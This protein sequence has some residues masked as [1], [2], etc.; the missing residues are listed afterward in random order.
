MMCLRLRYKLWSLKKK[1]KENKRASW[2]RLK[3]DTHSRGKT[4]KFNGQ[5]WVLQG[6]VITSLKT[7]TAGPVL[8]SLHL[9]ICSTKQ[10]C[11]IWESYPVDTPIVWKYYCL[12]FCAPNRSHYMDDGTVYWDSKAEGGTRPNPKILLAFRAALPNRNII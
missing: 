10:F 3:L 8:L 6:L 2:R 5:T 4:R 7:C 1:R 12:H 9:F 11:L